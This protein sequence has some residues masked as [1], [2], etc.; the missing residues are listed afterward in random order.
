MSNSSDPEYIYRR[1][2]AEQ[3]L[4]AYMGDPNNHDQD[5]ATEATFTEMLDSLAAGAVGIDIGPG[6]VKD[7]IHYP[8]I[9]MMSA[10]LEYNIIQWMRAHPLE[11]ANLAGIKRAG[12]D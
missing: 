8:K 11:A 4:A 7:P 2:M 12:K 6:E 5:F 10:W 1:V 9:A 3:E